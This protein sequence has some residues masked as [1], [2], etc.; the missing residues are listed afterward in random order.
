M[1]RR[2]CTVSLDWLLFYFIFSV[3]LSIFRFS[4]ESRSFSSLYVKFMKKKKTKLQRIYFKQL[5]TPYGTLIVMVTNEYRTK[6]KYNNY[7]NTFCIIYSDNVQ[8]VQCTLC[9]YICWKFPNR[10]NAL[11]WSAFN[12]I[13]KWKW[14]SWTLQCLIVRCRQSL[15]A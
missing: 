13:L 12:A 14:W 15:F 3:F 4:F 10:C 2:K 9:M 11:R 8:Y 7:N 6:E 1:C 5:E